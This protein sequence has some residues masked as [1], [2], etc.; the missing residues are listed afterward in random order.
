MRNIKIIVEYEGT[1]YYGWQKQPEGPTIQETIE[2]ALENITGENIFLFGS[3]RTDSGVH[4]WGQVANFKTES[5]IKAAE[6]Q[7]GLNS[8]LPKDITIKNAQ[9]VGLDF[10]AQH[11]VKS[12]TYIYK[13]F[14]S[15]HP[16]ALLRKRAW[17]IPHPLE[18]DQMRQSAEHLIGEHDFKAFA[19]SGAEVKTTVRTVLSV[20]IEQVN[21]DIL[22]FNIEATGFL[23]RMVRLI[24]G[25]MVQ[26]GKG[27]I[28]PLDFSEILDSGE[29]TKYVYAAPAHGLYLENV[30]Y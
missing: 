27:R 18:L 6:L 3:G 21:K 24:V 12:K 13:V 20:G 23:K 30:R 15:P 28:T 10:H 19:Q 7:M 5:K 8:V 9:E 29:K 2:N 14:N 17:Y 16:S 25:T 26:V 11:S 22:E 4:A 1:N